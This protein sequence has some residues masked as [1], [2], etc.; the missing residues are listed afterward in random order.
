MK[1]HPST[2]LKRSSKYQFFGVFLGRRVCGPTQGVSKL[3]LFT[4]MLVV[5]LFLA[6]NALLHAIPFESRTLQMNLLPSLN[7]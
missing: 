2:F 6:L 3:I 7:A 5:V 4:L 1:H